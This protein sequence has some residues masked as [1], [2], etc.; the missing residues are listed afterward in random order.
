MKG[1]LNLWLLVIVVICALSFWFGKDL[2][3]PAAD[4]GSDPK[5]PATHRIEAGEEE[6]EPV[7]LLVLNGTSEGG[8]AREFGLLLGRA[9]CVA[10]KVG[11]A[12][13]DHFEQSFLVNRQLST[14]RVE[15][16]A[17]ELGGVPIIREFDG[18]T[19]ADAVLVLGRDAERLRMHLEDAGGN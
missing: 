13:H 7:H 4:G 2:I 6:V 12:P 18:R 17:A 9:G 16:L 14:I 19:S 1:S 10:E 8:L 5:T 15:Q 11:N 3:L